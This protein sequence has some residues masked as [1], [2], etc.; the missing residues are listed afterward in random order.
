MRTAHLYFV[1]FI[2]LVMA[3]SIVGCSID[4]SWPQSV[5]TE[6]IIFQSSINRRPYTLDFIDLDGSNHR[7][8]NINENFAKPLWSSDGTVLFG[9]SSPVGQPTYEFLGY[10]AYWN[11]K[12]G[13]F[14]RCDENLP[15][16][17]QIEE[18]KDTNGEIEVMLSNISQIIVL[19]MESCRIIKTLVDFSNNS[20]EYALSGFSYYPA[21]SELLYGKYP[22][23]YQER[24]YRIIK[25][26]LKTG[27]QIEL[28]DGINPSW[29]PN[30]K[31]IAY[32]GIDGLYTVNSDGKDPK[33]LIGTQLFD[34]STVE[35]PSLDIPQPRWSPGGDWLLIHLCADKICSFE[36]TLILKVRVSDGQQVRITTGGKYPSWRP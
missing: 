17:S 19:S 2:Y 9:L 20:G 29:S 12:T 13:N 26:D 22:V 32:I 1:R 8:M 4:S 35:G 33:Q 23:P 16:F 34:L 21:T 25:F 11:T 7:T 5:P 27:D 3:L 6:G 14:K 24:E 10:P 30:G 31:Q 18:F 36:K 28:L 15:L